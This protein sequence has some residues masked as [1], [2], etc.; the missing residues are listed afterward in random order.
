MVLVL[1]FMLSGCVPTIGNSSSG[2]TK[3]EFKKGA[4]AAGFPAIPFYKNSKVLES[5]GYKG[6]FGS[7]SVTNDDI[8]KVVQFFTDSFKILGWDSTVKQN[9][10]TSYEFKINN[11]NQQGSI[12][13]NTT[14]DGKKTGITVSIAPR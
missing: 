12:I 11:S 2:A 10:A 5:Y 14:V 9:S 3:D 1:A 13:V 8:S 7:V 4:Y 6:K